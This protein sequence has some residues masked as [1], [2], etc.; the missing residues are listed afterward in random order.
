MRSRDAEDEVDA[1]G[2]HLEDGVGAL[3]RE[4]A[5]AAGLAPA[6]DDGLDGGDRARV[7]LAV[8][9]GDLGAA[10]PLVVRHR[11]VERRVEERLE[12]EVG[13]LT[14]EV[15][16]VD[17]RRRHDVGDEVV[18]LGGQPDEELRLERLGHLAGE[19]GADGVPR[20]AADDL[21]DE[22]ALREGVVA[23]CGAGL[24]PRRLGGEGRRAL[25]PVGQVLGHQGLVP[26]AQAGG[27]PHDVAHLDPLLAVGGELGPVRGHGRVEVELA[28]VVQHRARR[29]RSW[30]WWST[31]RW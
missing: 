26:A 28:A 29:G 23:R 31:T 22:V 7:A 9:G 19:E 12:H 30:S 18:L 6:G 5:H 24:P 16:R 3:G 21:A 20:D 1:V 4:Q 8:G 17:R 10:P 14:L 15:G 2:L 25:L 13:H 11:G 27:V